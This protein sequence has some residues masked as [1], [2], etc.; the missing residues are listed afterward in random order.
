M[1]DKNIVPYEHLKESKRVQVEKMFDKVSKKYDFLNRIFTF[2]MD[3]KWRNKVLA[4]IKQ[5]N[6]ESILDIATGTGDMAILFSKTNANL[7]VGTDI[8]EGMLKY[9]RDKAEV[10]ELT[11][12]IKFERQDAE[13]LKFPDELFDAVSVSYGIRNFENLDKGLSEICRVTKK[14]GVLVILETSVPTNKVIKAG[15]SFYTRYIIPLIA[16]AFSENTDAYRYLTN[17]A[18]NF[19]HGERM[20]TILE[21]AGYSDIIMK[22]QFFGAS[23]I[24]YAKKKY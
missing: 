4:I 1:V 22:P 14:E 20:K 19:P 5:N 11:D 12:R 21:K 16:S 13:N 15:Y 6:P 23:T 2:G 3:K 7:I 17:S 8:S 18:T 9:A 24:Y 10:M